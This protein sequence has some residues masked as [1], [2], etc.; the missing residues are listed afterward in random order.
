MVGPGLQP[1]ET[2]R[3]ENR[4]NHRARMGKASQGAIIFPS[5]DVELL[6]GWYMQLHSISEY[7]VC[8]ADKTLLLRKMATKSSGG[9][10]PALKVSTVTS[11]AQPSIPPSHVSSTCFELPAY[12]TP[13]TGTGN[14]RY[15]AMLRGSS[16]MRSPGNSEEQSTK[17]RCIKMEHEPYPAVAVTD[18]L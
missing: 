12:A 2:G 10:R 18:T 4:S 13:F 6:C 7:G 16:N 5:D 15:C 9:W 11:R 17:W 8:L 1:L 3:F 14:S